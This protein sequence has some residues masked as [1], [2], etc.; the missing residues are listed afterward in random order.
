MTDKVVRLDREVAAD[1][2]EARQTSDK[3][4]K[5][6]ALRRAGRNLVL[7][8]AYNTDLRVIRSNGQGVP[9][10]YRVGE[11]YYFHDDQCYGFF[12]V[13]HVH[14]AGEKTRGESAEYFGYDS[15]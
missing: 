15:E 12:V 5:A 8:E 11:D 14:G 13:V 10:G 6:R 9:S 2:V 4:A 7:R 1:V 3:L